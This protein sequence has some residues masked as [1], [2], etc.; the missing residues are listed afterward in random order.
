M[1]NLNQFLS[2]AAVARNG[3][4]AAAARELGLAP[5]SVAKSVARLESDLGTRLFHRTTRSLRLTE[6]GARLFERCASLLDAINA[7]ETLVTGGDAGPAGTLRVGAPIGYGTRRIVPVLSRL[8]AQHPSLDVEMRLS[9]E[10]VNL[11]Q[12]GLD[13]VIRIGHNEDSALVARQFDQQHL[14]LC[15]TPQYIKRHGKVRTVTD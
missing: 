14:M 3:S 1:K 2:F 9:D 10:R 5:S 11:V 15:A 7:L 4:F 8:L 12:E 6:E 13:A